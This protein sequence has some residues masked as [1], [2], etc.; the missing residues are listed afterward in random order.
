MPFSSGSGATS[1]G[2]PKMPAKP[3]FKGGPKALAK[4]GKGKSDGQGVEH[5]SPVKSPMAAQEGPVAPAE[6]ASAGAAGDEDTLDSADESSDEP[7]PC[8]DSGCSGCIVGAMKSPAAMNSFVKTAKAG[9]GKS[10]GTG[11]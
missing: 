10:K 1:P 5:A 8:G 11:V 3:Q 6:E 7:C 4:G 2:K 9:Y